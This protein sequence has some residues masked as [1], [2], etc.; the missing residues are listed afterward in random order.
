MRVDKD[1]HPVVSFLVPQEYNYIH[2]L[3]PVQ[4]TGLISFL[5]PVQA[6]LTPD[7]LDFVGGHMAK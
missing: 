3:D 7:Q 1:M 4:L 6:L 2:R 5:S